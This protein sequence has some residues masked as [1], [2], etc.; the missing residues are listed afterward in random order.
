MKPITI[1]HATAVEFSVRTLLFPQLDAL[2]SLGY[3]IRVAA[4][5]EHETFTSE[6]DVFNPIKIGFPRT[7]QVSAA[8]RATWQLVMAVRRLRPD[9][10]H[11]HSPSIALPIR[12]VP[13]AAFPSNTHLVHTVHGF[14]HQWDPPMSVRDRC[15]ERVEWLLSRKADILLFQSREDFEQATARHYNAIL[16]YIGNGVADHWFGIPPPRR[17]GHLR[18]LFVGRLVEDKGLLVLL[19]A[20][21]QVPNVLLS[22]AGAQARGERDGVEDALKAC[23]E[24]YGLGNRIRR[25]GLVSPVELPS[26]MAAHDAL[27]LPTFHPEGV[28]RSILEAVAAA[29]P[30]ITTCVRG[31]REV[32]QDG[33]N[34]LMV[35]PRSVEQLA[36]AIVRLDGLSNSRFN[37]MAIAARSTADMNHRESRVIE[38]VLESYSKL[39]LGPDE[40]RLRR[41]R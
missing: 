10:L 19:D 31:C 20:M 15:L 21:A 17:R 36:A 25:L 14:P 40:A 9:I 18:L 37:T 5:P 13:R 41:A 16:D 33:V 1:L 3:D 6:L 23:I 2:R 28:P 30:V 35:R 27:V 38:R 12:V 11:V 26:I 24:S 22:I 8:I 34:G 4:M 29:R 32:I 39:G 7:I